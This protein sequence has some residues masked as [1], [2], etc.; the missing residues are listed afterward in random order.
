MEKIISP[1]YIHVDKCFPQL[2]ELLI[3]RHGR[4]S[5]CLHDVGKEEADRNGL[6]R[7]IHFQ[8]IGCKGFVY[9]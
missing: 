7:K 4:G 6:H 9:S 2:I 1:I 5:Y 3:I 8:I